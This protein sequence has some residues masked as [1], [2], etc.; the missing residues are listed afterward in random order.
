MSPLLALPAAGASSRMRG[1]DK[2][3]EPIGGVPL[4]RRQALAALTT[5]CPVLVTLPEGNEPRRAALEGL[6]LHVE[7]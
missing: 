4:L 7:T 1:R 5:G 3:L 2:L 6:A